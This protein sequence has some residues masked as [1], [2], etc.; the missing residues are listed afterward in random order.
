MTDDLYSRCSHRSFSVALFTVLFADAGAD[1][2][3]DADVKIGLG[4][5]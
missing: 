5:F 4:F 2:N 1:A 3:A